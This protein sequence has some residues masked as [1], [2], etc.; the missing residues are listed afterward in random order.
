MY[1]IYRWKIKPLSSFITPWQSDTIYGHIFWALRFL[2]GEEELKNVID[3]FKSFNPPFICSNGFINDYIPYFGSKVVE[4]NI[5]ND[6]KELEK[7]K[8]LK[9]IKEYEIADFN[10]MRKEGI[11]KLSLEKYLGRAKGF[12]E[13][14]VTHN[15]VNRLA[16]TTT[17][18]SL[19]NLEEK[20]IDGTV[21]IY[22]KLRNDYEVEKLYSALKYIEA[23]GFGKKSSSGKGQIEIKEFEEY[24]D[25]ES[26]FDYNGYIVLS[27]YVPREG[28]YS[29]VISGEILTKRGK[30]AEGSEI[31]EFPFKK[32][33]VYYVPGSIFRE[34]KNRIKG[35]VLEKIHIDPKVVQIGIPF[36]LGVNIEE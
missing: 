10:K 25:F 8:R 9:R 30:V 15:T 27:N 21:S 34:A 22:I 1:K 3:E 13:S 31:A 7:I 23:N 35:R 20:F 24:K 29:E 12:L 2:Y 18:N 19:Y 11:D 5:K 4:K 36:V 14:S 28:D 32:P 16:G 26:N 17:E 6:V 33:F